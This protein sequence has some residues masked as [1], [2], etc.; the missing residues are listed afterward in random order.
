MK[1][2]EQKR[3]ALLERMGWTI[4]NSMHAP[5]VVQMVS[6]SGEETCLTN[7]ETLGSVLPPITHALMDE[8]WEW[9]K[10]EPG[11][12]LIYYGDAL[13]EIAWKYA[14]ANGGYINTIL[15]HLTPEQ[16][17]DAACQALGIE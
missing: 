17:F 10:K 11:T 5:N 4:K 2:T 14:E 7:L 8:V 3:I 12:I 16:K 1:T 15:A 13:T 6:P 9:M